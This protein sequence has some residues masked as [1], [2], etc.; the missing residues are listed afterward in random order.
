MDKLFAH[1]PS[2]FVYLDDILIATTDM[3]SHLKVLHQVLI[4]LSDNNL[5]INPDKSVFAQSSVTYFGHSISAAG[6]SP[7]DS[8][9][10]AIKDF[11]TPT[12]VKQLQC[13]LGLL[14]FY[15]CFL[16]NIAGVLPPLTDAL[17]GTPKTLTWTPAMHSAFTAAKELLLTATPLQFPDPSSAIAVATDASESQAG[18]VL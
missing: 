16:P 11:P 7:M 15:R 8:H 14:N 10:T 5:L 13:F 6:I 12:S 3:D 9:V 2:V 1:L 4:I 18:A 17:R